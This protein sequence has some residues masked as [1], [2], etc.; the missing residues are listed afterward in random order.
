MNCIQCRQPVAD[1]SRYCSFCGT[2]IEE[3]EEAA[4]EETSYGDIQSASAN[5][6]QLSIGV[7]LFLLVTV[8]AVA[9]SWIQD[10]T[11]SKD[12][13]I[14]EVFGKYRAAIEMRLFPEGETEQME[15]KYAAATQ[16]MEEGNYVEA[17]RL[18][19]ELGASSENEQQIYRAKLNISKN[20]LASNE[21]TKAISILKELQ[22]HKEAA[23]FLKEVN[24]AYCVAQYE[25]GKF[26]H[27]KLLLTRIDDDKRTEEYLENAQL[28][29]DFSGVWESKD[30]KVQVMFYGWNGRIVTETGLRTPKYNYIYV[31]AALKDGR[32]V[33]DDYTFEIKNKELIVKHASS[34]AQ[35]Y[36]KIADYA[37]DMM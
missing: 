16:Q 15:R 19:E 26:R 30:Q 3:L 20:Y 28:M 31:K 32:L 12:T 25:A 37:Y 21:Y 33:G 11:A 23:E 9:V 27:A 18:Y 17:I 7:S 34:K 6:G 13:K 10:Y 2:R 35:K 29:I 22:D 4:E 8:L 14:L 36:K 1:G 24:F 5:A